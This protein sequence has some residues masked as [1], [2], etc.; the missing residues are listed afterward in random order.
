MSSHHGLPSAAQVDALSGHGHTLS[1]QG[2]VG[3]GVT[4]GRGARALWQ[5]DG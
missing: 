4:A 3:V 1:V 2:V 5:R